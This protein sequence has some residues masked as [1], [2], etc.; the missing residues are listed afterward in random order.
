MQELNINIS[1][2]ETDDMLCTKTSCWQSLLCLV[3]LFKK[4]NSKI[5]YQL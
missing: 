1:F 2:A 4:T 5:L 3:E